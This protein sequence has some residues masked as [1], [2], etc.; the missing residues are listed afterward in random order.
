M[1]VRNAWIALLLVLGLLLSGCAGN[2]PA[3]SDELPPPAVP[4]PETKEAVTQTWLLPG[5]AP[6]DSPDVWA[7]VNAILKEELNTTVT[8]TR[9]PWDAWWNRSK[10]LLA[11]D[12]APDALYVAA[13]ANWNGLYGTGGLLALEERTLRQC[14]PAITAALDKWDADWV[15]NGSQDGK[16]WMV[17]AVGERTVEDVPVL[18]R[19][20]LRALY[21]LAEIVTLEDLEAYLT[22][23]ARS[24]SKVVP[25]NADGY[26]LSLFLTLAWFQPRNLAPVTGDFPFLAYAMT[27][28]KPAIVNVMEDD[29]FIGALG[30][31]RN[32]TQSGALPESALYARTSGADMF[33]GG[34]S[35]CLI[36]NP[37]QVGQVYANVMKRHPEWQPE[38]CLLNPQAKRAR[39]PVNGSGMAV[40]ASAEAPER[41]LTTLDRM[42]Q[43]QRL[44][45]LT[46]CGLEGTHYTLDAS[47]ALVPGDGASRYPYTENILGWTNLSLLRPPAAGGL[48]LQEIT[49]HWLAQP[50]MLVT[51]VL[52]GFQFNAAPVAQQMSA[53][54][55]VLGNEGRQLLSG[56]DA[57]VPESVDRL[58]EAF[59]QAGIETV[60]AEMQRQAD[61]WLAERDPAATGVP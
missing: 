49:A 55:T 14:A 51:P 3:P 56:T 42:Y 30:R 15:R 27:E 61:A 45:D 44:Q 58:R 12:A 18:V 22:E 38:R 5:T 29:G 57:T 10:T 37:S 39:Q 25:W 11:A 52:G 60:R 17:P 13:G 2:P 40:T 6:A 35:A 19:G 47:G 46:A 41:V 54:G 9:V 48:Y 33:Q 43:D 32:L 24:D 1:K 7:E 26:S 8:L 28:Q 31:L 36:G 16:L 4:V 53:L 50:E 21:G 59:D 34:M 20:D 23:L